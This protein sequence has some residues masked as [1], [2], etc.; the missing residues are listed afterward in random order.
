M[1]EKEQ[2]QSPLGKSTI[3]HKDLETKMQL[4]QGRHTEQGYRAKYRPP[5]MDLMPGREGARGEKR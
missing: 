3:T 2:K 1:E 5:E 4:C